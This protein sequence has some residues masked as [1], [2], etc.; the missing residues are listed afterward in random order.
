MMKKFL[1][2]AVG[3]ALIAGSACSSSSD[4]TADMIKQ[5]TADLTAAL[6]AAIAK[7]PSKTADLTAKVQEIGTKY[8]GATTAEACK[9]YDELIAAL[10][11]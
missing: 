3:L 6:Q 4:C 8:A 9:A 10:K 2:A 1:F 5:K 11:S 7:D